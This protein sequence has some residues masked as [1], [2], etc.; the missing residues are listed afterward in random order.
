MSTLFQVPSYQDSVNSS[1]GRGVPDLAYLSDIYPAV[2][3]YFKGQ[4]VGEGNGT[5][6]AAP[7]FAAMT[8]LL[9]QSEGERVGWVNQVLY[10]MGADNPGVYTDITKGT[11]VIGNQTRQFD[12]NGEYAAA[13]GWDFASGWGIMNVNEAAEALAGN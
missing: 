9:N 1:G 2:M 13:V 11:N 4:W 6:Q 5:S 7:T 8:M 3:L 12:V 10:N